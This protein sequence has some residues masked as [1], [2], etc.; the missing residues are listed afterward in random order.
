[1]DVK[2]FATLLARSL[3]KRGIEREVVVKHA[4]SLVRTFDEEDL[5]EIA[6]YTTEWDFED[7]SDSLAQL[8]KDK[9]ESKKPA[10]DETREISVD[11]DEDVKIAPG[12]PDG[13]TR[14]IPVIRDDATREMPAVRDGA[15]REI[16]AI[17]DDATKEIP[18]PQSGASENM[19]TKAFALENGDAAPTQSFGSIKTSDIAIPP[20]ASDA[21]TVVDLPVIPEDGEQEI[22]LDE[23]DEEEGRVAL[24]KRGRA[25]FWSIAVLTSPVT[26]VAS[27]L[28]LLVFAL[29]IATVCALIAGVF[30]L[31]CAEAVA[32]G[33]FTLVGLIYG[34]IEIVG[35]SLGT[36]I[37]EMGLGIC[38][39]GI[40]LA[41]GILTYNVAT[42]A[43]PYA[44]RQ[45]IAFEGYALK[46]V[47]PMLDRFR[48]ECNKL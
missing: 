26:I 11:V 17:R 36:G 21:P 40:A 19:K 37:Y 3:I 22:Y 12:V 27:L 18:T 10:P 16:P 4:V 9:E 1:M 41:V 15:T 20:E 24:T 28:V 45:L 33:G 42:V 23:G 44:L 46:R 32:G 30:V 7:L 25:F 14:E 13:A 34:A 2:T 31:V 48:E 5:S 39:G 6:S 29:G 35:G 38:C 47:G 43:L 8:I